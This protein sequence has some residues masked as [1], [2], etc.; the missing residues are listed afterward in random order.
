MRE[1][2]GVG[3]ARLI[4]AV[5]VA[6]VLSVG[7]ILVALMSDRPPRVDEAP[8]SKGVWT[9]PLEM[10]ARPMHGAAWATIAAKANVGRDGDVADQDSDHDVDTMGLALYAAR[11][12]D[13]DARARAIAALESAIGTEDGGRWLAVGRNLGAYIIAADVLDIRSGPIY[14]WLRS[15]TT[16]RLQDNNTSSRLVTLRQSAWQSGSNASVQEGFAYTALGA[17][18][19]DREILDWNW[20]AFRRYAGDRTSPHTIMSADDS[21]QTVPQDPVGIQNKGAVKDGV[22]IDGAIS[23]DMSRGGHL[24]GRLRWT[25]YPW[26]GLEG[27]VPAA[28]VLDRAG[29]PAFTVADSALRR[30]AVYLHSLRSQDVD[31]YDDSRSKE[32]KHLLNVAYDLGYPVDEPVGGGRTVGFTDWT[33]PTSLH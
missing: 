28:V 29:Y 19:G 2:G 33:H 10:A 13:A 22:A 21:W 1:A 11:T 4:L 16:K 30:A 9:S 26:V 31:W 18:L 5:A 25:Q 24:S 32:I 17:Y 3:H 14:E 20:A 23:A 12:G 15:F 8:R 27:A 7:I 6:F